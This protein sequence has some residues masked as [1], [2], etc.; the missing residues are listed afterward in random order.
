MQFI[1]QDVI[2]ET[3]LSLRIQI[4][5]LFQIEFSTRDHEVI[6]LGGVRISENRSVGSKT[7]QYDK[8]IILEG[9]SAKQVSVYESSA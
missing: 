8:L 4:H 9:C 1:I 3:M 6:I 7:V 5:F 2:T